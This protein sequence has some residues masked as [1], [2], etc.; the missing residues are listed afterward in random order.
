MDL[1][2]STQMEDTARTQISRKCDI[3]IRNILNN[4]SLSVWLRSVFKVKIKNGAES[5]MIHTI[6]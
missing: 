5:A 3:N 1:P 4:W 2:V 6:Y